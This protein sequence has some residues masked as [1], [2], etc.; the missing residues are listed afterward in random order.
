VQP[1]SPDF[2]K[3]FASPS[4]PTLHFWPAQAFNVEAPAADVS[5]GAR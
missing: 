5:T 3:H 2:S 1:G 4:A